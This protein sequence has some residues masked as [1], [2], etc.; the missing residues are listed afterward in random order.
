MRLACSVVVDMAIV[1]RDGAVTISIRVQPRASRTEI[2]GMHGDAL[3]IR[4]AAPPV[5]G[6][7]N[8]ECVRFLARTLGVSRT[9][10]EILSGHASRSKVIRVDGISEADARRLLG[11]GN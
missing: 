3:K 7:A 4:L 2:A 1:E 6:E 11:L 9:A 10:V 8:D 5:D